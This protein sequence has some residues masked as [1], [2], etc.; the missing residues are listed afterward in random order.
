MV[1]VKKSRFMASFPDGSGSGVGLG[2]CGSERPLRWEARIT[3]KSVGEILSQ[4]FWQSVQTAWG[5]PRPVGSPEVSANQKTEVA[6]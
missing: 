4:N 2:C 1:P 5:E 3:G 6:L